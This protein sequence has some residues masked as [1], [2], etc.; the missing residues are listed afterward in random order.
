MC[1]LILSAPTVCCMLPRGPVTSAFAALPSLKLL[2]VT[3]KYTRQMGG[4]AQA[5][6]TDT[7]A[8]EEYIYSVA[9]G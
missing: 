9:D 6:M 2:S 1:V 5:G 3:G 8:K 7:F 4:D